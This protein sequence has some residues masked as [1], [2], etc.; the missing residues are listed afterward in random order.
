MYKELCKGGCGNSATYKGWCKIG[1]KSKNRFGISCPVI[2]KKRGESISKFRIKESKLGKNPMQNPE[3]CKKNHSEERN[4]KASIT[5]KKLG[6]K[7]LLPQQTESQELKEKRRKNNIKSNRK[8]VKEGKHPIQLETNEKKRIRHQKI[9]I[10]IKKLASE[11]KLYVQNMS[12]EQKENFAK[13]ISKT[14]RRR[15][16]NGEIKLSPSWK[17][18]PY[19]GLILRSNWEKETARFLDKN[20]IKWIYESLVIP[21][22]D[23]ERK[24]KANTIPDFYIPKYNT[25]IEVK[26]NAEFKSKKTQDKAKAI[27]KAG[28]NFI[29]A[30]RKEI[31][32][33]KENGGELLSLIKNE[34]SKS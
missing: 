17:K 32:I 3:I 2:T 34:K 25:I 33:M 14:I 15:I 20:K 10:T 27:K 18:V 8:L 29:L 9:A 7:G 26:S 1:W 22:F 19:N 13:K 4:K 12:K 6:E 16:K 31:E 5:L 21:Y 24:L 23:T 11:N 28:Y 30:G